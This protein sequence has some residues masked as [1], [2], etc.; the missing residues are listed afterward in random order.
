MSLPTVAIIVVAAGSGTRLGETVPKAFVKVAGRT[1]LE[2]ALDEVFAIVPEPQVVVVVP[3]ELLPLARQLCDGTTAVVVPGG[4]TRQ[5]SVACGVAELAPTVATVLVH[6]AAR[7]L[8]PASVIHRVINEVELLKQGVVPGLPV[9]NT[10]KRVDERD[11]VLEELD[12]A[13]MREIQTPQGFPRAAFVAAHESVTVEYTDD[14]ALFAAAGQVVSIIEGDPLAF[15]ITTPWDLRRAEQLLAFPG[16]PYGPVGGTRTGIGVDVHALDDTRPLWFCGV[17]WPDETGLAGHSD[18]DAAC[19]AICDALLSA[20]GLGDVGSRF[21]T[22]DPRFEDAAGAEFIAETVA[23]VTGAGYRILN[24]AVQVVANRPK[25][26]P[27]RTELE[28]VLSDLVGAPVS[29]GA[30]TTDGLGLTGRG[31]GI[32]VLATCLL[33][34]P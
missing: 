10:V 4:E 23:L 34:A 3:E 13:G 12:R 18:G 26:G 19:H 20:A 9:I 31:E 25:I 21:G 7:A 28:Q 14:A 29:V 1:I 8:T 24:V 27:R 15:K 17:Y 5:Q 32:A 2:R 11:V 6:D 22:D 33:T 16:S 30:T